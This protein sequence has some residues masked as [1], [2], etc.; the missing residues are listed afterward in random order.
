MDDYL[1]DA[2]VYEASEEFFAGFFRGGCCEGGSP[3][4]ADAELLYRHR[5]NASGFSTIS[6]NCDTVCPYGT[7]GALFRDAGFPYDAARYHRAREFIKL[8]FWKEIYMFVVLGE[9]G[10]A[11]YKVTLEGC[12]DLN[13]DMI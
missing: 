2:A 9:A 11:G 6:A 12:T 8:N 5:S 7:G 4:N 13:I 10:V 3:E 1:S